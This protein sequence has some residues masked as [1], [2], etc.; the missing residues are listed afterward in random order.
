MDRNG[1]KKLFHYLC[2]SL[3]H[4][5][6]TEGLKS[7]SFFLC[8]DLDEFGIKLETLLSRLMPIILICWRNVVTHFHDVIGSPTFGTFLQQKKTS[9]DYIAGNGS[10]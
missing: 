10:L 2:L 8:S 4:L 1:N 6:I 9:N 7:F 3:P 5:I